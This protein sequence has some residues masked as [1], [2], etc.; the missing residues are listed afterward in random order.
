MRISEE[1][2]K[3]LKYY[4]D[5]IFLGKLQLSAL[6]AMADMK[7]E[8]AEYISCSFDP[9]DED[10]TE[11]CVTLLFWKPAD[12]EDTMVFVENSMFFK[13]LVQVCEKHI[14]KYPE[15]NEKIQ[16]YINQIK[17]HLNI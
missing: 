6:K 7:G 13:Y 3:Y 9:D 16:E 4:F 12:D 14:A 15:D 17:I 2:E 1:K 8:G 11:G 10:Y 5:N